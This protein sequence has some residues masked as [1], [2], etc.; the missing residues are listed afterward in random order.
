MK[1]VVAGDGHAAFQALLPRLGVLL[2][3]NSKVT[4]DYQQKHLTN[5]YYDTPEFYFSEHKMGFRVRGCDGEF[6]QTLKTQGTTTG[7]LHQRGEYN[8]SLHSPKPE[9]A[10][11]HDV[12][13]PGDVSVAALDSALTKRFSTDFVRHQYQITIDED[14]VE[15]V[16]DRGLVLTDNDEAPIDEVE[17]ELKH[18]N[19]QR[20][21]QVARVLNQH[22]SLRL[23]D[24]T[25]AAM[26]YTL[27]GEVRVQRKRLPEYLPLHPRASTEEAFCSAVEVALKHWQH[28]EQLYMNNNALKYLD[29]INEGVYLLMQS[30]SLYLPVL[31]C[32]PLL[33]LHKR[34]INHARKWMW[35]NELHNIRFLRAKKGPFS[36][37]LN[38]HDAL[39]S[40]LQGR[41]MGLLQGRS[42]EELFFDQDA[43]EI[44][45]L[46]S[47]I[48][49][50]KPWREEATG[51]DKPVLEHAKGWLS[52]SWQNVLQSLSQSEPLSQTHYIATETILRQ[53][54]TNG[55]LL[56]DLFVDERG[57]FRAPWHDILIGVEE[58]KA[59]ITLKK[60]LTETE[61]ENDIELK[62]WTAD[63][64][65][66]LLNVIE[67]TRG[68]AIQLEA[69]W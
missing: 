49:L 62:S 58:L 64:L 59:L 18:G 1:F 38:E 9:L 21:F 55:F 67:R 39:M 56:S 53:A 41:K 46:T 8:L 20:V 26:G 52:Q 3:G 12:E 25:K 30:I 11:F 4:H 19:V 23:S 47:E 61:F 15:V 68:V 14:V 54:L 57:E 35:L 22:L 43:N 10:L 6:E 65:F 37:F 31:Q 45:I 50:R 51:V 36:H 44:K 13:W 60:L 2:G 66:N 32:A 28:H 24:T 69:Y 63:K 34:L 48:L 17:I 5:A 29:N 7:G 42:P 40:Y 33:T 27:L 16:F